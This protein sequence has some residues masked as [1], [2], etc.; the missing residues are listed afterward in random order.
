MHLQTLIFILP[1]LLFSY[2]H[3][4]E[5]PPIENNYIVLT[6]DNALSR[7][8]NYN[9]QIFNSIDAKIKSEYNIVLA[10]SDFDIKILP[11]SRAGYVG[12][13]RD[14]AGGSVGVGFD[15]FKQ[16]TTGTTFRIGP[17]FLKTP[18]HYNTCVTAMLSHPLLSGFDKEYQLSQLRGAE[19]GLRSAARSLYIA[20]LQLVLRTVQSLYD[21]VKAQKAV[22]LNQASYERV[23]KFFQTAKLK[24]RIGM[25][26]ALDV[27]RAE[28]ELQ[29]SEDALTSSQERLSDTQDNLRDLLALPLETNIQ[30]DV[31]LTYTEI[32]TP[33]EE[34]LTLA[35]KNRIEM[36]QAEDQWREAYR[37]SRVVKQDI[38][39]DLNLV[40]DYSNTGFDEVFTECW[41]HRESKWG[42]GVTSNGD[43]NPVGDELAYKAS[44]LAVNAAERAMDQAK[45]NLTLEVKKNLRQQ[46]RAME[47]IALQAEQIKTSE[48]QLY[49]SQIKFDRGLANNFD[50][51]QAEKTLRSAQLAYWSA[52]IEHIVGEY[53]FLAA[54]GLLS[55][56]PC[57]K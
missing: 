47:K 8:L 33:L 32:T 22:E 54:I 30:V 41:G 46:Q 9:R 56:K 43:F 2:L 13:G 52:L 51:I 3:S 53:Q 4:Q 31:P 11:N 20:Q 10:Q 42:I 44:L 25:S 14:G 26:D 37:L 29:Q 18:E 17:S 35:L 45:A 38:Y 6:L 27:Y 1:L 39:P 19:F 49:L 16:F 28:I 21:I 36:E 48:G 23:K 24:E 57:I 34:A 55:D 5:Q 12:G 15:L 50:V 7:A 40:L